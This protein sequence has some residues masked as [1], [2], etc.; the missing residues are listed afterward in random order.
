VV[1]APASLVAPG[2]VAEVWGRGARFGITRIGKGRVYWWAALNAPASPHAQGVLDEAA[3]ATLLESHGGFCEPVPTLIR[4]TDPARIIRNDILDRRPTRRWR[5]DAGAVLLIGDAAHPTTPNYGQGGCMAI[6]DAAVLGEF[7]R[8]ASAG[9]VAEEEDLRR[10]LDAFIAFRAAKTARTVRESRMF[11]AVGQWSHPALCAA[12]DGLFR[13]M[14]PLMVRNIARSI[15][16]F[17]LPRSAGGRPA[18]GPA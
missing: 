14:S 7:L 18:R 16:R 12:R 4:M 15:G 1:E 2:Y 9:S 10:R 13:L 3:R 11:G 5:D 6:E 17:E 8:G